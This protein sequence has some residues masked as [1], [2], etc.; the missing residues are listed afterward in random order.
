V[1][2]DIE[3]LAQLLLQIDPDLRPMRAWNL[4]GGVSALVTAVAATRHGG[5]AQTLVV[6]QYGSANLRSDPL[7]ASHEFAL[8]KLLHGAG[9]PVPR[10]RYADESRTIL[11][12]PCLVIDFIDGEALT[13]PSQVSLPMTDVSSQLAAELARLHAAAYT[14]A[15]APYLAEIAG[16]AGRK[17][18]TWPTALDESLHEAAVRTALARI[19]PPPQANRPVLLHGDYWPGN[20][21]WRDGMLVGVVDWE[22]AVLGDPLADVGNARMEL[23]MLFGAAAARDFTNAYRALMPDLDMTAL[24]HW[25][26]YASLRHAGRM[27]EWG[28]GP[29]DLARLQTGHQE[30]T[31]AALAQLA[32]PGAT[33]PLS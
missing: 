3:A 10:P 24:Q 6:R 31:A 11:P 1:A 4:T 32:D 25:D 7:V 2:A 13:D 17:I 29:A 28:L 14:V 18:A 20:T 8:L 26:L 21:L 23:S 5:P 27:A 9:L 30:F 19:W 22:D 12:V 15:D 16:I 33:R